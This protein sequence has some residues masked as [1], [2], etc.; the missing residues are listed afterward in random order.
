[1]HN[2]LGIGLERHPGNE[3]ETVVQFV[4]PLGRFV[5]PLVRIIRVV[6]A[7]QR[8]GVAR[9]SWAKRGAIKQSG[10]ELRPVWRAAVIDHPSAE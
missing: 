8:D 3:T 9:S 6:G 2:V 1:M 5:W 7:D 10:V 4:Y